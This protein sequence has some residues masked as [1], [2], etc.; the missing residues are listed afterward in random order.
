VVAVDTEAAQLGATGA[1]VAVV[2]DVDDGSVPGLVGALR[3]GSVDLVLVDQ[4]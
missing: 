4:P 3:A 2:L 1:A